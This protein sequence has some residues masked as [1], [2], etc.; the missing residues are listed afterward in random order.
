MSYKTLLLHLELN[1]DNARL[2][3]MA[4]DLVVRFGA[5]VIGIAACQPAETLYGENLAAPQV[6]A[7]ERNEI[8]RQITAAEAQF[9][10]ILAGRARS[11]E[12]RSTVTYG[13][14]SSYIA[15]QARAADLIISGPDLGCSLLDSSR[16]VKLGNLALEAGRPLLIVPRGTE[17]LTPN[18]AVIGWKDTREARRTVADALPFLKDA[19][20][21]TVLEAAS[22]ANAERARER[23]ND[24]MVWLKGHDIQA[25]AM[26]TTHGTEADALKAK[27]KE[28]RCDLFVAG[29]YGHS[30]L[31]EFVFGGVTRDMLLDPEFCVLTSH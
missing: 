2:L 31:G 27:L 30:R 4:G 21:V 5:H 22:E 11:Q 17:D 16:R 20:Q 7:E 6:L 13:P 28:L 15:K 8:D 14:L 1:N 19:Q 10:M 12:W 3:K 25:T 24:V 18:H 9:Q 26:V 23:V 29:A